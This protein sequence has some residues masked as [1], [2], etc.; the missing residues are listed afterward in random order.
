MSYKISKEKRSAIMSRI[1]SRNTKPEILVRKLIHRLGYRFRLHAKELPGTPD[2]VFRP[3]KK[4]IFVHGCFWHQHDPA[5]CSLS[6]Q[7][8]S[9]LDYWLPKLQ[10]NVERDAANVNLLTSL[11]WEILIVWECEIAD[12]VSLECKLAH[13]LG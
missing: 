6:K 12:T 8:K 11:G 3:K 4:A 9:R 13:F 1:R 7:P 2:I 10:R 5:V